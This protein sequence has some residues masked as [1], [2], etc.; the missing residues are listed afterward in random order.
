M[1]HLLRLFLL[2]LDPAMFSDD[3]RERLEIN[4][5]GMKVEGAGREKN[6][7]VTNYIA[8]TDLTRRFKDKMILQTFSPLKLHGWTFILLTCLLSGCRHLQESCDFVGGS[9]LQLWPSMQVSGGNKSFDK[10]FGH[11]LL[12]PIYWLLVSDA[13][14]FIPLN[15]QDLVKWL[16]IWL[17]SNRI[18]TIVFP[19]VGWKKIL[20][21]I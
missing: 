21:L 17:S 18:L 10:R 4:A 5:C 6:Y 3:C 11:T 19:H 12:Y 13:K 8:L 20:L 1:L 2:L 16:L 9:S 7:K 14:R 15:L